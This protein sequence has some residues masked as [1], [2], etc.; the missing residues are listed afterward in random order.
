MWSCPQG[1]SRC[2]PP[3][4]IAVQGQHS[5]LFG[6]RTSGPKV[7]FIRPQL[8]NPN[9][10]R[11]R[12]Q[13]QLACAL[14]LGSRRTAIQA[15]PLQERGGACMARS[16][17]HLTRWWRPL[18]GCTN[19]R[20]E[21]AA[22]RGSRAAIPRATRAAAS[23]LAACCSAKPPAVVAAAA[24][25]R[26]KCRVSGRLPPQP[27]PRLRKA[28]RQVAV[29]EAGAGVV[30]CVVCRL[31]AGAAL[32]AVLEAGPLQGAQQVAG[33]HRVR[34]HR[35]LL[36]CSSA[37]G[38]YR[39]AVGRSSCQCVSLPPQGLARCPLTG[40]GVHDDQAPAA[41]QALA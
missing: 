18:P 39:D 25:C 26:H 36:P 33:N 30:V 10:A 23:R 3:R 12:R 11:R 7:W 13:Q 5:V 28:H 15:P 6:L 29:V 38:I 32:H 4:G 27:L 17:T 35:E 2:A 22:A 40:G 20:A 9:A 16:A 19:S 8:E 31:Q 37:A 34:P 1:S 41:S 24:A 14:R 21:A